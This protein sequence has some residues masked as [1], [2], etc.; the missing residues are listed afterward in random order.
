MTLIIENVPLQRI[1]DPEISPFGV[2]LFIKR[3]DLN[4]KHISGNKWFKLKYNI[5][6]AKKQQKKT[7]LTFGGAY[8]N[9]I[10]ATAA[11]GKEFGFNTIGIIRGEKYS[12]LNPTLQFSQDSGMELHYI[13]REDYKNKADHHFI[14]K[15]H[16]QLGDFY[17]L[18]EGGANTLA[19]KG[20]SEI[21]ADIDINFDFVCCSCGTGTTLAGLILS[22]KENQ[23]AI[24]FS[25]LKGG[26]FLENEVNKYIG[27]SASKNWHINLDYHF[28]GYAKTNNE[29]GSFIK[30]FEKQNKIP[31]DFIY[32]GKMIYGIYDL[33]KKGFFK[34]GTI[35]IAI[36]TGGLQG[37][38][39]S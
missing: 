38:Q 19:V 5:E 34:K 1:N 23:Q 36:H 31:L 30:N 25:S 32:T 6:E 3:L 20:C 37:N 33:I 29:L 16:K 18:P 17:L 9:H 28:G 24:G 21:V 14:E 4:H 22:L 7:L 11:A 8:S 39:G 10:A 35:I 27:S 2:H 12:P 13:P 26:E 15:L